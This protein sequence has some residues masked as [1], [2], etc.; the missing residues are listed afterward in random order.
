[1]SLTI[2]PAVKVF[3]LVGV[4]A[5]LLLVGGLT[6]LGPKADDGALDDTVGIVKR[7][8]AASAVAK[9]ATAKAGT[10]TPA[11]KPETATPAKKAVTKPAATPVAKPKPAVSEGG[12]PA[13]LV[14]ALK[15]E[16]VVVVALFDGG[17]TIDPMAR[18]EAAAGA[19]LAGAG[20]VALDVIR[21]QKAA[22]A[23]MV[24]LDAVLRAPAVLVFARPGEVMV[25]LDG[26][27]DR[28]AVAQA[29]LNAYR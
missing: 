10:V 25:Q 7:T 4:A 19:R 13:V 9:K 11:A 17:A 12:L 24:E 6:F 14:A 20:F 16:P 15:A 21:N 22:E 23:L 1:M 18:D 3:A 26:F 27:R 5:A 2:S 8:N 28:D 29:A